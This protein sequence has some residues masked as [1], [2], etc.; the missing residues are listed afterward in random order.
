MKGSAS[1][2]VHE[3]SILGWEKDLLYFR[4]TLEDWLKV[5]SN[6]LYLQ[7]IFLSPDIKREMPESAEDF[8]GVDRKWRELMARTLK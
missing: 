7:P 1:A 3:A 8:Q 4:D 2:K 6:W 5:Q